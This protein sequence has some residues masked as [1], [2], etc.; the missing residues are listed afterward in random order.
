MEDMRGTPWAVAFGEPRDCAIVQQFDP[1]DGPVDA[2]AVANG[3]AGE[4]FIFFIPRGYL[5]L[6]LFLKL[7]E[8]LMKVSDGLCILF[9][10]LVIDPVL[11]SNSLDEGFGE[12]AESDWVVDVEA[13]N[14]V[15]C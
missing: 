7:F 12:A 1:L 5:L 11:L 14:D 2:V 15:G 3:K 10:L 6:G 4:T 8:P 9:L 13:F